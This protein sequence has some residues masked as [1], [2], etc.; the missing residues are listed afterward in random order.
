MSNLRGSI[1]VPGQS[2]REPKQGAAK[3]PTLAVLRKAR[4][5]VAKGWTRFHFAR[6][7]YG[8][9]VNVYGPAAC[10]FCAAGSIVRVTR[11]DI[12]ARDCAI[13]VLSGVVAGG[14]APA[15]NDHP[16][17]TKADVL[18]AFDRAIASVRK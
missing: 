7:K 5:L 8:H 9:P 1:L 11:N 12:A 3:N 14:T 15:F 16:G 17:T 10:R 4:A 18:S 13:K 2:A 6:N